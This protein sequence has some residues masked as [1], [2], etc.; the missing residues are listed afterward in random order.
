MSRRAYLYFVITF[1]IGVILGAVGMYT[2]AWNVGRWRRRSSEQAVI[3][4]M[5]RRLSLSPQQTQE[6]RPILDEGGKEI[7]DLQ[8]QLHPQY[9]A[10][11]RQIEAH[12]RQILNPDQVKK[13]DEILLQKQKARGR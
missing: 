7:H 6:L 5:Q 1:V 8:A 2:Y 13:F 3:H 11:H 4:D 12:I 9:V 10:L